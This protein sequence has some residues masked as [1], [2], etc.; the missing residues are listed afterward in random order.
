MTA[1][2]IASATV[3]GAA[4]VVALWLVRPPASNAFG[5]T[6]DS[7]DVFHRTVRVFDNFG[8]PQAN[9]NTKLDPAF[10]GYTGAELAIWKAAVEWSSERHGSGG[11][12]PHQ[13]YDLGSGGANFDFVWLGLATSVGSVDDNTCSEI[14]GPGGGV[15]AFCETPTS[16]GWRIRFYSD[17]TWFDDPAKTQFQSERD[18]QGVATHELGHALGL[19]HSS[20]PAATMFASVPGGGLTWR[21]IESDD[22]AGAQ[23]IYGVR[24]SSKPSIATYDFPAPGTLRIRG[25]GFAPSGNEVWF[26]PTAAG[27]STP[28]VVSGLVSSAGGTEIVLALPAGVGGG[29]VLVKL[30]GAAHDS[31]STPSPFDLAGPPCEQPLLFGTAKLTSTGSTADLGWTGEPSV[32]T[33]NLELTLF[34]P[35]GGE[36][37]I[38][39][40]STAK[41]S[42]PFCGGE[43]SLKG[44]LV[45]VAKTQL[46]VFGF[47]TAKVALATSA[48]GSTR[49]FQWWYGDS[50]DPFGCGTS[51]ALEIFVCP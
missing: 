32:A 43:L 29:D 33:G 46:D 14:A 20:V 27:Q 5:V 28:V 8:D 40:A 9:S 45:R 16:D 44:P 49:Y 25:S 11:G 4:G 42:L 37:A 38:L 24:S 39:F 18:L 12:D 23:S 48:I 19:A 6:G 7:L 13:P 31:L 41:Q 47:A 22:A 17:Q 34:G 3:A 26:T 30:P 15:I 21:S 1:R 35:P 36:P 50:G 51:N 2:S 10:P